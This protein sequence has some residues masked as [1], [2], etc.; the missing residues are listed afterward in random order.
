LSI[1]DGLTRTLRGVAPVYREVWWPRH[2]AACARRTEQ[3]RD[4]LARYG[5]RVGESIAAVYRENWPDRPVEISMT[6]Y[7][8]WAGAY[9]T[10]RYGGLI[11]FSCL[12]EGNAGMSGLEIVF[13]EA[14]HWWDDPSLR[15]LRRIAGDIGVSVPSDL[16]HAMIFYTAG[17]SVQAV[18]PSHTPYAEQA[19]IWNRGMGRFKAALDAHWLPWLRGEIAQEEALRGLLQAVAEG[20]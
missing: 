11:A 13:H 15:R 16:T 12:S 5:D 4:L 20:R 2:Q 10:D 1:A 17:H 7:A 3:L 8:N 18:V 9:S 14:M 6:A 19:G